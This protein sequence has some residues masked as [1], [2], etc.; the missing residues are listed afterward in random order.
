VLDD[1]LRVDRRLRVGLELAHRRRAAQALRAGTQLL[2]DLL[3][4]VALADS[5]LELGESSRI[6]S[7][8]SLRRPAF[9]GHAKKNRSD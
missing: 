7:S 2:E 6:N 3:V 4:R 8:H 1:G 9:P 5:G